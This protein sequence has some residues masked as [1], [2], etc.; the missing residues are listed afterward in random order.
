MQEQFSRMFDGIEVLPL[1]LLDKYR[2]QH[3]LSPFAA[4]QFLVPISWRRWQGLRQAGRVQ[5]I[6]SPWPSVVD[7]PYSTEYGLDFSAI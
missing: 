6:F 2:Q 5:N 4:T 3:E 7:V 1:D